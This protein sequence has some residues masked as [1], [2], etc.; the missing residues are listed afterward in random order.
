MATEIY[1]NFDLVLH[2]ALESVAK[3][4]HKDREGSSSSSEE[5][6]EDL[7]ALRDQL[8]RLGKAGSGLASLRQPAQPVLTEVVRK[9]EREDSDD[10]EDHVEEEEEVET[11]ERP[12]LRQ[13]GAAAGLSENHKKDLVGMMQVQLLLS[14]ILVQYIAAQL[15]FFVCRS[16][17]T[18][19]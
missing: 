1:S 7:Q 17:I 3:H 14:G 12:M 19:L 6:E 2:Q 5:L 4:H 18:L 8:V 10:D 13:S 9:Y 11:E 16:Q 15:S